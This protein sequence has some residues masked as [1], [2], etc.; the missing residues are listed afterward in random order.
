VILVD[1]GNWHAPPD[2]SRLAA[3]RLKPADVTDVILT[4]HYDHSINWP[5]FSAARILIGKQELDWAVAQPLGHDTIPEFYVRE[6]GLEAAARRRDRRGG[7]PGAHGLCRPGTRRAIWSMLNGG[8][9]DDLPATP[10]RTAPR[11]SRSPPT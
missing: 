5:V 6:S 9:R 2:Q 7:D 8:E 11:C 10:P 4:M 3:R 1:A